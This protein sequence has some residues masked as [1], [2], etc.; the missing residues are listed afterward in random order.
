MSI[1]QTLQQTAR[2][3]MRKGH[4]RKQDQKRI[5]SINEM[6]KSI[7]EVN[8]SGLIEFSCKTCGIQIKCPKS[9]AIAHHKT[10]ANKTKTDARTTTEFNVYRV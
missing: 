1:E 3:L 4:I 5:F 9:W 6:K 2:D 10:H 7:Y 8:K